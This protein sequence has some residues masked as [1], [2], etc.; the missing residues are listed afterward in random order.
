M[1]IMVMP[2]SNS[3]ITFS[4][5]QPFQ[6]RAEWGKEHDIRV[7]CLTTWKAIWI[8]TLSARPTFSSNPILSFGHPFVFNRAK[9]IF[10]RTDMWGEE[11]NA[12]DHS[13]CAT[14]MV[15]I[16]W[17]SVKYN[18]FHCDGPLVTSSRRLYMEESGFYQ[19][20][21]DR[22]CRQHLLHRI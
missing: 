9:V 21:K 12:E 8:G 7:R 11:G 18:H 19:N 16:G 6:S 10:S 20:Q 5:L 3:F 2:C 1:I 17:F 4:T 13:Y 15:D 22:W 14:N